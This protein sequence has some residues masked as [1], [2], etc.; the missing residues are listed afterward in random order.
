MKI[1]LCKGQ[2]LGPMSGADETLVNYAIQLHGAG[3]SVSVLLLYP[4]SPQDQY[5][6]RL[7]EAGIPVQAV[8]SNSSRTFLS[9]G[10]K[11]ARR[12]LN[13]LPSSE[14]LVRENARK[15][16]ITLASR[17]QERCYDFLRRSCA[18]VVHVLTPDPGG[19]VLISA[20]HEAHI[21]VVYQEV[22]IP[23]H[24]PNYE[25]YYERFTSV[26][27]L[28]TEVAAVSP[29]IAQLCRESLPSFNK[30]SVMPI[31]TEDLRNGH[32]TRPTSRSEIAIGFA[33]RIERL[34]GPMILLEAFAA[35]S[36]TYQGLRLIIAGAGALK[37]QLSARAHLLGLSSQCEFT[38]VYTSRNGCQSFMRRLDIFALPSLTEGTP[39]SIIEAM[40]LGLPIIATNVGGIPDVVTSDAGIL[41]SPEDSTSL[42]RAIIRLAEDVR[43]RQRMGRAARDRY[44]KLFSPKA[45]LPVL[46]KTYRRIAGKEL[47]DLSLP[48]NR[49]DPHP[50]EQ[51]VFQ[52]V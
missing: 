9:T 39:N 7:R 37:Q 2:F 46:L 27:P 40:S 30:L 16:A 11:I 19:R 45:V 47:S 28:C 21:P 52:S 3:H 31:L 22:G 12:L 10:R 50:W 48:P 6:M 15:L 23:Y 42:T 26:L 29:T 38:G 17:Y 34:K 43:L 41:V 49:L 1:I 33:G 32:P 35:A 13:A 5:Y 36:R 44:E 25:S 51:E 18:D 24:P 8:A 4:Y 20:A 14:Y